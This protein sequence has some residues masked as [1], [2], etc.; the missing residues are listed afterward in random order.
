MVGNILSRGLQVR[1][2]DTVDSDVD[3]LDVGKPLLSGKQENPDRNRDDD[4]D[5][6]DRPEAA[7]GLPR[8]FEE[9]AS[10]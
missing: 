4:E 10:E 1:R 8:R 3:W 5:V 7:A 9:P 6:A 2:L